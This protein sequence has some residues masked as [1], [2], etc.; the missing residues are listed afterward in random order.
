MFSAWSRLPLEKQIA[1]GK[2]LTDIRRACIPILNIDVHLSLYDDALSVYGIELR[3]N[4]P[5]TLR[6]W[7]YEKR[8]TIS[9]RANYGVYFRANGGKGLLW[10]AHPVLG[11]A[12]YDCLD[13]ERTQS[14]AR[15]RAELWS[16]GMDALPTSTSREVLRVLR[17]DAIAERQRITKQL[18]DHQAEIAKLLPPPLRGYLNGDA[19]DIA[20]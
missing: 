16:C 2:Y 1:I 6:A 7:F 11:P 9:A 20:A 15:R 18:G 19:E 4:V 8:E 17:N 13:L 14:G 5:E 3:N 10:T 12:W